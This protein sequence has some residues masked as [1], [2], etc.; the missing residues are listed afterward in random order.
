MCFE[1]HDS[2]VGLHI[3][4]RILDIMMVFSV[5]ITIEL[6]LYRTS[7]LAEIVVVTRFVYCLLTYIHVVHIHCISFS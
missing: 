6:F 5:R 3:N 2:L 1:Y 7:G 4:L